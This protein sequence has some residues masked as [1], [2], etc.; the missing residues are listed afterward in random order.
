MTPEELTASLARADRP[1]M[2][3][4]DQALISAMGHEIAERDK[5][6]EVLE[7]RIAALESKIANWKWVGTWTP[8]QY[9]SGN[10]VNH[11]GSTFV[12]LFPTTAKPGTDGSWQLCAKRG[13]DGKDGVDASRRPTMPRSQ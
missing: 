10:H 4:R 12:C 7:Q 11:D 1:P 6:I 8:G 13:R 2:N 9:E 3:A 5:R